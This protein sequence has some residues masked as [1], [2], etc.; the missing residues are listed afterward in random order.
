MA[1][2]NTNNKENNARKGTIVTATANGGTKRERLDKHKIE[3][4]IRLQ[5]RGIHIG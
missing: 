3:A 4:I 2:S 5:R 1:N